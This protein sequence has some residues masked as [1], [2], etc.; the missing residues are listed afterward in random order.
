MEYISTFDVQDIQV[1]NTTNEILCLSVTYVSGSVAIGSN[2]EVQC[3]NEPLITYNVSGT[4]GCINTTGVNGV[5]TCTLRGYDIV[6]G[7]IEYSGPA[8]II[9]DVT[10]SGLIRPTGT[11]TSPS[12][13]VSSTNPTVT[14][15]LI[16][17]IIIVLLTTCIIVPTILILVKVIFA[18]KKKHQ[19]ISSDEVIQV[20]YK[21]E[22]KYL[23]SADNDTLQ[24]SLY[25]Y[26]ESNMIT[27]PASTLTYGQRSERIGASLIIL[28]QQTPSDTEYTRPAKSSISLPEQN[29]EYYNNFLN[30]IPVDSQSNVT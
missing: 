19:R 12:V 11:M 16:I 10:I 14:L 30:Y 20:S 17:A 7:N 29:E 22:P 9:D 21:Q 26:N 13:S 3:P 2:I 15:N 4:V 24:K 8:V 18:I 28:R 27:R 23:T 6:N 5:K 1:V 25:I